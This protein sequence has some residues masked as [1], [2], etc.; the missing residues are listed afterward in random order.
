MSHS[1]SSDR[2]GIYDLLEMTISNG[3]LFE[4]IQNALG[5]ETLPVKLGLSMYN[6]S[7]GNAMEMNAFAE[8]SL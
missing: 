4:A 7:E 5:L 8:G 6:M 2:K 3:T 1:M